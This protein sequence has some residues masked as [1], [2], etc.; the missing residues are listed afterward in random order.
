MES[1]TILER[2]VEKHEEE[3]D[4]WMDLQR[5]GEERKR[6]RERE[7]ERDDDDVICVCFVHHKVLKSSVALWVDSPWSQAL[8]RHTMRI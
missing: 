2:D 6:E 8:H 7:R 3:T 4:H 1:T 5:K